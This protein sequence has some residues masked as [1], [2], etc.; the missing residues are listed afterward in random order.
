MKT[1]ELATVAREGVGKGAAKQVR[2]EGQV[3]GILYGQ[4]EPVSVSVDYISFEKIL[5]TPDTY[6]VNLAIGGQ[7]VPSI[8]RE[9]QFHPVTDR[10]LHVDFLRVT[11]NEPLEVELPII[12][13]GTPKGVRSGGKLVPLLRRLRI[14]G[15]ASTMPEV[16]TVNVKNL[17]LGKT[18]KVRDL[19]MPEL[20]IT[21]PRDASIAMIEIPRA[22]R[23]AGGELS[24]E[25][26]DEEGD[27]E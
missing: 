8:I 2:K 11:E 14:K 22:V 5:N 7:A 25:D 13:E 12:L 4:G 17:G 24:V 27:E 1:V 15:L 3:P 19:K 18:I 6:I 10:V 16:I 9:V 20:T 21:T 23:Q 26:D